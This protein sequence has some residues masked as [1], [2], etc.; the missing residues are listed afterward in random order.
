MVTF[1]LSSLL[2]TFY[3]GEKNEGGFGL[4]DFYVYKKVDFAANIQELHLKETSTIDLVVLK[5]N[6]YEFTNCQHFKVTRAIHVSLNE[7]LAICYL[8]ASIF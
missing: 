7:V 3:Y 4:P 1:L 2:L 5:R 8:P 6:S